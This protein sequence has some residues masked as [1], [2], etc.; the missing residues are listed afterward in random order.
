MTQP[1]NAAKAGGGGGRYYV[2]GR[3]RYWSVTTILGALPK[4]ALKFWAAKSV[5]E[6]AYDDA[7]NWLGMTRDRAVDYLKR[8]P[9]RF[10]GERA[11]FGS[12]IHAAA[13][14]LS[15]GRPL[16]DLETIDH[17]R[18]AAAYLAW[19]DTRHY[20]PSFTTEAQKDNVGFAIVDFGGVTPPDTT[21]PAA[22]TG[23][24][25]S[26]AKRKINLNWTANGE[27]DLA[28]YNVYRSN[29]ASGTFTKLNSSLVTGTSYT[30]SGLTSGSTWFYRITAVD[31]SN[32]ES[33]PS[34]TVSATAN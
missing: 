7:K 13:E 4:D 20:F 12:T 31:T 22:P 9:L 30:N 28:G 23:L 18:A 5:A 15:L 26:P 29:S 8:E 11:N 17:R 27:P 32:N 1:A 25:A 21:P 34:A 19:A 24:T 2:W 6:F 14:A 33:A 16:P 10:T 3:E